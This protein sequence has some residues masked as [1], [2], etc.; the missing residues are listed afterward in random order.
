[1]RA[2]MIFHFTSAIMTVTSENSA[3]IGHDPGVIGGST[4]KESLIFL[5]LQLGAVVPLAFHAALT[6]KV[7]VTLAPRTECFVASG[8]SFHPR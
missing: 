1:M 2:R 4:K 6:P 5:A 7:Y 3:M 8:R